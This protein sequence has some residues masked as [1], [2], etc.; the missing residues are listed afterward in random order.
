ME[1]LKVGP[2]GQ[3]TLPILVRK[4]ILKGKYI[5][6]EVSSD[7]KIM[8]VP[9]KI[10]EEKLDY[11]KEELRKIKRLAKK[12]KTKAYTSSEAKKHINSL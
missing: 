9:L 2:R 1:I 5:G 8:L 12:R 7:G 4:M 10:E 3:I 6:L 11:T